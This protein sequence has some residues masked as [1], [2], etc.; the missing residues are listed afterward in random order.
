ML[1]RRCHEAE[2]EP[3]KFHA[4]RHS[5]ALAALD[6][7]LPIHYVRDQLGHRSLEST[8]VYTRARNKD[9]LAAYQRASLGDRVIKKRIEDD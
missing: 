3:R 1:R 9:P 7:G 5:S 2:I 4:L 6:E 8:Q